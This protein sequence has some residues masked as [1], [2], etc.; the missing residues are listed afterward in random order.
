[1]MEEEGEMEGD[2]V[3][4]DEN[5]NDLGLYDENG[6]PQ[7]FVDQMGKEIPFE[8]VQELSTAV[9]SQKPSKKLEATVSTEEL[10]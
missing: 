5:G 4:V 9:R 2:M 8:E 7:K 6:Q 10:L 3:G 1:M